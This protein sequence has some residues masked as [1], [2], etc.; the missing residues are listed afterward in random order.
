MAPDVVDNK[1]P[2]SILHSLPIVICFSLM[3][4]TVLRERSLQLLILNNGL[5]RH[6][7][8]DIYLVLILLLAAIWYFS[9]YICAWLYTFTLRK[10]LFDGI[11]LPVVIARSV[12]S[13]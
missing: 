2:L 13:F 3:F 4:V 5:S 12:M 11:S 10:F 8:D 9:S 1:E 6:V 7:R